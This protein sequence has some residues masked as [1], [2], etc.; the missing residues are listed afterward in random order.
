[1]YNETSVSSCEIGRKK[2]MRLRT[3]K[4]CL[5]G[6][7]LIRRRGRTDVA[8]AAAHG[9]T[10]LATAAKI[11][12]IL[13]RRLLSDAISKKSDPEAGE[14]KEEDRGNIDDVE[15]SEDGTALVRNEIQVD[16]AS[17]AYFGL[18]K[19]GL[20]DGI[21]SATC[22]MECGRWATPLETWQNCL[23]KREAF[24]CVYEYDELVHVEAPFCW[25][26]ETFAVEVPASARLASSTS[27]SSASPTKSPSRS[28]SKSSSRSSSGSPV[29]MAAPLS[30]PLGKNLFRSLLMDADSIQVEINVR[31]DPKSSGYGCRS[32]AAFE[33][34]LLPN[35]SVAN[36]ASDGAALP[37]C[38]IPALKAQ[39]EL[40]LAQ[41][42]VDAQNN[43][44]KV[45][46]DDK[47][48]FFGNETALLALTPPYIILLSNYDCFGA[49]VAKHADFIFKRRAR[50]TDFTPPKK[51]RK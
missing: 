17:G 11:P 24:D 36:L 47:A 18:G 37:S 45:S 44:L 26:G 21:C 20:S 10:P 27:A 5:L 4:F 40:H 49:A 51:T 1:M 29:N 30:E 50:R 35:T 42:S 9:L 13:L 39:E 19:N 6:L 32:G 38:V 43:K 31:L 14:N 3:F 25:D 8:F 16:C 7:H 23:K 28:T 2:R 22:S 34:Q 15:D 48:A 12:A 33:M 41:F 46:M